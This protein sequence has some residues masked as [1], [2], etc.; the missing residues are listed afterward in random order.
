MCTINPFP[1]ISSLPPVP[2]LPASDISISHVFLS[3]PAGSDGLWDN[4]YESEITALV[5]KNAD[6]VQRA[7]DN[8]AACARGHAADSEFASPYTV[9]ALSQG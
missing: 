7:A 8:I 4:A 9:Q 1:C 5:P 3:Y 6:E 2:C